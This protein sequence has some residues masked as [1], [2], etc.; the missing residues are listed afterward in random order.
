MNF[1]HSNTASTLVFGQIVD[2]G[3]FLL[4]YIQNSY[5]GLYYILQVGQIVGE[6]TK[7]LRYGYL[8]MA[9]SINQNLLPGTTERLNNLLI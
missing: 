9:P 5:H 3:A 4:N 6:W 1:P 7:P 2:R 8:V